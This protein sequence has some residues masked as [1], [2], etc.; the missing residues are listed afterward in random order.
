MILTGPQKWLRYNFSG[1]FK[2][3]GTSHILHLT[4][5]VWLPSFYRI[6]ISQFLYHCVLLSNGEEA[7]TC[8]YCR[9]W[10]IQFKVC[11]VIFVQQCTLERWTAACYVWID[12]F[13]FY[14]NCFN[15]HMT[16]TCCRDWCVGFGS[17][18]QRPCEHLITLF[19][20]KRVGEPTEAMKLA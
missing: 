2:V 6:Y 15:S 11:E 3:I 9:S 17:I 5:K 1:A 10:T 4:C 14:P 18:T 13:L 8:F 7:V 16:V 19:P 12:S 20:S